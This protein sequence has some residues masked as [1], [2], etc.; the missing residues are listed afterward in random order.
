MNFYMLFLGLYSLLILPLTLRFE[1]RIGK[2]LGYRLRVSVTG[3]PAVGQDVRLG[4][5]KAKGEPPKETEE[6][7][8]GEAMNIAEALWRLD[9]ALRKAV[10]SKPMREA[11][12]RAV[13]FERVWARVRIAFEDAAATALCYAGLNIV[14]DT[15]RYL[16]AAPEKLEVR[17]EV[18]FQRAGSTL[19]AGGILFVRLGSLALVASL[20]AVTYRRAARA[21]DK[22][23]SVEEN[24][25]AATSHR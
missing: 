25:Y 24:G 19:T 18:D 4:Q 21:R 12:A 10:F 11:L 13:R 5:G 20:L 14:M 1:I 2:G 23:T 9:P 8:A 6:D 17:S 15:L 7:G 22:E 3:M 16:G